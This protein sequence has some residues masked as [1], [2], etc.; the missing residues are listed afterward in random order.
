[1]GHGCEQSP[2]SD[3]TVYS[4][5][6]KCVLIL[7]SL[8]TIETLFYYFLVSGHIHVLERAWRLGDWYGLNAQL[9]PEVRTTTLDPGSLPGYRG[10]GR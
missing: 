3:A 2:A 6:T 5:V 1:M 7:C 10:R 8:P 9:L 4:H